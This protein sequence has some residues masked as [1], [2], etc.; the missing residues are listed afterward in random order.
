MT[1]LVD[2]S[3]ILSY[4][5]CGRLR[6]LQY[7]CRQTGLQLSKLILPLSTG[8]AIH[9]GIELLLTNIDIDKT[10]EIV[11]NEYS[12]NVNSKELEIEQNESQLFVF[13]E[14]KAL[15]EGLIRVYEK[16]QL[17]KLL[18]EYEVLEV[19]KEIEFPLYDGF[20]VCIYCKGTGKEQDDLSTYNCDKCNGTGKQE[21]DESITL[22]SKPDAILRDKSTGG[23]VVYSLKTASTWTET[24]E[25][26]AKYDAQGISELIATEYLLGEEVEAVKM[27]YLIKGSRNYYTDYQSFEKNK[28]K[29]QNSFL[30]H[31]YVLDS[32]FSQNYSIK[33]T[34]AKGWQRFNVWEHFTMKEWVDYL[35]EN[36]YED[37]EGLVVSPFPYNRS[38]EDIE[39]WKQ[40][41]IYQEQQIAQHLDEL[42][43]IEPELVGPRESSKEYKELL[44][45]YFIKNR[46]NCYNYGR[47][48]SMAGLC[49]EGEKSTSLEYEARVPHH[50]AEL[51]QLNKG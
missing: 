9:R 12:N 37:L 51:V 26:Q 49:W 31:A 40:S 35:F 2:R 24:N 46:M 44:N 32:G 27:D 11:L 15:I 36:H 5:T 38:S 45:K 10:I 25:K 42:R 8:T 7:H 23:L 30:C 1:T 6:F 22:M 29:L 18:Q 3:R 14:Q 21:R 39:D 41:V 16:I 50:E 20:K 4:Q 47:I 34:K 33:Y 13:N 28:A 48:C 43:A 19:E 17:P